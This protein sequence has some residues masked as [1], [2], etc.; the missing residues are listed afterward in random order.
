MTTR[1]ALWIVTA[2]LAAGTAISAGPGAPADGRVPAP[3]PQTAA[4]TPAAPAPPAQDQPVFRAG[5]KL[6]L[7]DVSVTG[8]GDEPLADLTPDD[9]ELTEDGVPQRVEQAT[10]VRL[11]GQPR[12]DGEALT[13]RSQDH[14]IAEAARDDVRL[15]AVFMDD[16][17][18]GR[19]PQEMLPLRKALGDF[20][21]TMMAP[22]DLVT[23]MNP[24]TP[25]SALE[26]TRD[27]KKLVQ[28]L[29]TYEGR[30]DNFIGRSPLE[31]SQNM[32][33]NVMRVRSQVVITALQ[34]LVMH[35]SGLREGRKTLLVV[36]Q[37]IPLLWD[38][39]LEPDFQALLR[40]ANRGNVVIH[41]LD[42]RGLGQGTMV[43]S[44]LFRLA[45]ETGGHAIVNT[46]SLSSGLEKVVRDAS[47]YYLVGYT[48]PREFNDGKFHKINVKVKRKGART[49]ARRGYWAPSEAEMTPVAAPTVEPA[50]SS[51]LSNLQARREHRVV[52]VET[53]VAPGS[54]G[55]MRVTATW[56]P[57]PGF[58][59]K[60][61]RLRVEVRD[62]KG[63][64]ALATGENALGS[65]GTGVVEL[66]VPAG[67]VLVRYS[68]TG[69]SGDVVDRWEDPMTVPDLSGA[70][71]AVATP[72]FVRAR[73]TAAFQA[74]RRGEAGPPSPD[75]EFRQTDMIVVRTAI[76]GEADAPA[77]VVAEVLTRE[78]KALATVPATT[79]AGQHQI[80]LPVRSLALGEYVLRFTATR[81]D[82]SAAA[83]AGFAIV[84]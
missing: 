47:H 21:G 1:T 43:H 38:I 40:E 63:G 32:S 11:D 22:L 24:I 34:A 33:R 70:T 46:N 67:D 5:V 49:V 45:A 15:F 76:A 79:R 52:H 9:F 10:L 48:P 3:P 23:V 50:V 20:L 29:K 74:L 80:E 53:G 12:G 17:H 84:R 19:F 6:V 69:E 14:A 58:K 41:T 65:D 44:T 56:R 28:Q 42:P 8:T 66:D 35:L 7:V 26:W 62:E 83:T 16:Y 60:P 4:T 59:D 39:S 18:L 57:V 64:A 25:L 82:A 55:R 13:I 31:E 81:G 51:A 30:N 2:V 36:S 54:D 61:S 75:R 72:S 27:H 71:L 77:T 78:G 68:A 73:T 37:G